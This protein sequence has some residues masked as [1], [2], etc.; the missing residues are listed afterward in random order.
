[1]ASWRA[2]DDRPGQV[3]AAGAFDL[4]G[5]ALMALGYRDGL[6]LPVMAVQAVSTQVR[7][8]GA[9][10]LAPHKLCWHDPAAVPQR[11]VEQGPLM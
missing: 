10:L 6:T 3:D 9:T 7:G 5:K 2:D 11:T 8:L 1:M 4:M